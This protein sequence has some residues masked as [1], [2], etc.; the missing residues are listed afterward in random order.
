MHRKSSD[1]RFPLRGAGTSLHRHPRGGT[2]LTPG[3]P[4][5]TLERP[6]PRRASRAFK[7]LLR[8]SP[9]VVGIG[10]TDIPHQ[11]GNMKISRPSPS[12]VV[13]GL[14]LFVSL[15]GT[16]VAAVSLR[17]ERGRGRRQE[18]RL[19]RLDA[20]PRRRPAGRDELAPAPTRAGCP[21]SSWPTSRARQSFSKGYEVAD[22]AP[23]APQTGVHRSR[24]SG[25][26]TA[27]C[28]D[29]NGAAGNEDPI[30]VI[31]FLNQSGQPVNVA[32]RVGN[33]DGAIVGR[34]QPDRDVGQ[35]RRLEHVQFHVE[36]GGQNAIIT[37]R[38]APGWPRDPRRPSASSSAS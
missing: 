11:G 24:A 9:R 5:L 12:M 16:S 19:G 6:A 2:R 32:R 7:A 8:L 3:L 27:T 30:S 25:T 31:T 29:Q 22:N 36:H 38:R 33:G 20:R 35:H 28:N 15:G 14:A 10:S 13:A 23:G 17:L 4:P 18:R 34:R 26:L 37:G 21:A 1:P